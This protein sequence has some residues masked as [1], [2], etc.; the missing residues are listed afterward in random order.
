MSL[1]PLIGPFLIRTD[2]SVFLVC[3]IGMS[4][5]FSSFLL[6]FLL[7]QSNDISKSGAAPQTTAPLFVTPTLPL[8]SSTTPVPFEAVPEVNFPLKMKE[9]YMN[10]VFKA[11]KGINNDKIMK[12][13]AV[14]EVNFP[15]KMKEIY[16]YQIFKVSGITA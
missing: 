2:L 3:S 4:V 12:F 11:L 9:T 14:P 5:F 13:E 1:V 7:G 16:I 10:Q 6:F 15:L 8:S